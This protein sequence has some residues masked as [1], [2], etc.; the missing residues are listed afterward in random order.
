VLALTGASAALHISDIPWDGPHRGRARRPHRGRARRYPTVERDGEERHRLWSSRCSPR[1]H[2]DGRGRRRRGD[3]GRPHRRPHVRPPP[4]PAQ[5]LE[6]I[7]R[8]ARRSASRSATVH[9]RRALDATIKARIAAIVDALGL[10]DA[11]HPRRRQRYDGYSAAQ[12]EAA[13]RSLAELGAETFAGEEKLVKAEFEERK[14]HVV[15]SMCVDERCASTAATAH[16]PPDHVRGGL[17]PRVHGSALFQRGETQAIVTT[18]L[19]TS[20]DEQKID[21]LTGERGSASCLHYNFPPFSHRR[22]QADARP[23][24]PRGGPRRPRRARPRAHDPR[25][26]AVPLHHPH[27]QRDLESNGSSSMAAVCGGTCRLMDAAC[28]SRRR[29]RASPWASSRRATSTPS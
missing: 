1:R 11:R 8:C 26:R 25:R 24:P 9:V 28:R 19:G 20:T 15:R 22:D 3:R 27:R 4:G 17:L 10:G 29:S 13:R 2:R 12:E 18:T 5:V 6:L 21:A 23:R 14:A 16:H 7:E